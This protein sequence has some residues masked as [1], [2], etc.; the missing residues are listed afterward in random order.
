MKTL[1]SKLAHIAS[2][3]FFPA[4]ILLRK[5]RETA[6]LFALLIS[7]SL[8][9]CFLNF[10]RTNTKPSIDAATASKLSSQK[11]H[12]IIHFDNTA[13]AL[14]NAYVSNDSLYGTII[15]ITPVQ[16]RYLHPK[17]SSNNNR[18]SKKARDSTVMEV[19]LYTH[20][21]LDQ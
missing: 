8:S 16:E 1:H 10:Y 17:A 19:H 2:F 5:K 7:M 3:V 12:F 14:E 18:V 20:V 21:S 13:K 9:S 4:L 11:K 6:Y 15:P